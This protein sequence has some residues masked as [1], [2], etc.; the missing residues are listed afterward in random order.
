MISTNVISTIVYAKHGK[1]LYGS[2]T[3]KRTARENL[4]AA[5]RNRELLA[6]MLFQGSINAVGFEQWLCK[7]LR[8]KSTLLQ[9]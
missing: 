1:K 3:G 6:P 7:E 8:L 2:R 9:G 5:R 4:I